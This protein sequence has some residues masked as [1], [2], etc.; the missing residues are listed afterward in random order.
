MLRA[1]SMA[2]KKAHQMVYT[3]VYQTVEEWV[4][5]LVLRMVA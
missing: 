1:D 5:M 2:G 3:T 4:G